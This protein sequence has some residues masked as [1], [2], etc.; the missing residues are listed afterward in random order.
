MFRH[1]CFI[2]CFLTVFSLASA[3]I[4]NEFFRAEVSLAE[5][6]HLS[7][8]I[9]PGGF[10]AGK[11]GYARVYNTRAV[12]SLKKIS[13]QPA[14]NGFITA[15]QEDILAGLE[16]AARFDAPAG[17]AALEVQYTFTNRTGKDKKTGF[18]IQ[19]FSGEKDGES[20]WFFPHDDGIYSLKRPFKELDFWFYHPADRWCAVSSSSDEGAVW[21]LEE[22]PQ[23]F[24]MWLSK[25]NPPTVEWRQPVKVLAPGAS[26]VEKFTV[27]PFRGLKKVSGAGKD[28]VGELKPGGAGIFAAVPGQWSFRTLETDGKIAESG[29]FTAAAAG[30]VVEVK[31]SKPFNIMEIFDGDQVIARL[32][33]EFKVDNVPDVPEYISTDLWY[34]Y[35]RRNFMVNGKKAWVVLPK[36]AAA[37]NPWSWCMEFPTAFVER[38]AAFQLLDNG[39]HHANIKVGNTF[40]A[41]EA[42]KS[43]RMFYDLLQRLKLKEKGVLIGISRGGLYAYRF[44]SEN[45]DAVSVIYGDAPVC[46][47]RSW[48]GPFGKYGGSKGDWRLLKKLYGFKSDEEAK[49]YPGNPVDI[50]DR[51]DPEKIAIIHV[52]GLDDK[53]VPP[54][55]NTYILAERWRKLG[56]KIKIITKEK[57]GHHPHG[58]EDPAETVNFILENNK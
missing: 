58:L 26:H 12:D 45:P 57:C 27:I 2:F 55:E 16:L 52:I 6:G 9:L 36:K 3:E 54:A 8:V 41:P 49:K 19:N 18:T 38:C 35:V 33:Q 17:R 37:G 11:F 51:L 30:S 56:G 32:R 44:A 21:L 29:K 13:A 34:G 4:G 53:V 14:D 28:I 40:G 5:G 43:F 47:F 23:C 39:Y 7:K 15:G 48:P 1:V 10:P 46:D 50:L 20:V 42:Q 25:R 24:Y 22:K 31:T